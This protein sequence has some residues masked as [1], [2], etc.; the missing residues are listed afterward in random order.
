MHRDVYLFPYQISLPDNNE[1]KVAVTIELGNRKRKTPSQWLGTTN[2]VKSLRPPARGVWHPVFCIM[3][4]TNKKLIFV[5]LQKIKTWVD[6]F[7]QNHFEN[8]FQ[9]PL[10]QNLPDAFTFE[11][12]VCFSRVY[13]GTN[14]SPLTSPF[15]IP[16]ELNLKSIQIA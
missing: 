16:L 4:K 2:R 7:L 8:L 10:H 13:C 12:F 6:Y 15:K 9:K 14:Y 11:T 5:I 1:I 3:L